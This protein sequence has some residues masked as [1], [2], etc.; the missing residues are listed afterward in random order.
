MLSSDGEILYIGHSN[1]IRSRMNNHRVTGSWIEKGAVTLM[2]IEGGPRLLEEQLL[3]SLES[4]YNKP[5]NNMKNWTYKKM[6]IRS[7]D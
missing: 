6:K 2:V 4:R 1:N 3:E 7:E 5:T